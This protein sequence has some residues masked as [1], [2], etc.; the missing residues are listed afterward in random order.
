VTNLKI[1]VATRNFRMPLRKALAEAGRTGAE[2][3]QIDL[4]T[5]LPV[6]D[7]SQSAL[8]EI[9]KLLDDQR[10][11]VAS[12][13]F[14]TRRSY[15]DEQQLDRRLAATR[16]AMDVAGQLG[17]RVLVN[18]L[19]ELPAENSDS[20]R[21]LLESLTLL[22]RHGDRV[23]A[24]LALQPGLEEP[25]DVATLLGQLPERTIGVDFAPAE[26]VKRGLVSQAGLDLLGPHL[27]HVTAAD[28]VRESAGG[29]VDVPLGRGMVDLPELFAGLEQFEYQGWATIDHSGGSDPAQAIGDAVAYLRA[30]LR[31]G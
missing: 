16:Q 11:Q 21:R 27:L 19:G 20:H 17:A 12:V 2:G 3:V 4:R 29:A 23:G 10:L 13:A 7:C 30:I 15:G 18:H 25:Q 26:F 8:R 9:R 22:A 24:R 5:E 14:P 28:A 31:D 1:G 6:T